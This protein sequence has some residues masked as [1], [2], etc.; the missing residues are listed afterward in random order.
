VGFVD[1]GEGS[2][3]T[4]IIFKRCKYSRKR[5]AATSLISVV[6]SDMRHELLLR[7]EGGESLYFFAHAVASHGT[8]STVYEVHEQEALWKGHERPMMG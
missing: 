5:G 3:I 8:S 2:V 6:S 4:R 7:G 1:P